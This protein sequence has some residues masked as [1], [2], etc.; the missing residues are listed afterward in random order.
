LKKEARR[1]KEEGRKS[2]KG[3]FVEEEEE[4][5]KERFRGTYRQTWR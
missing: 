2:M 1:K 4:G 3:Q 5:R